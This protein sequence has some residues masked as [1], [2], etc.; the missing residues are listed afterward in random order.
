MS[1]ST[2]THAFYHHEAGVDMVVK[3]SGLANVSAQDRWKSRKRSDMQCASKASDD[4]N[5]RK[6]ET[7]SSLCVAVARR[8]PLTNLAWCGV[9]C[10]W[11]DCCK[12]AQRQ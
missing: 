6:R 12:C 10:A 7:L 8:H 9:V 5:T 11:R 4:A 1:T 2:R 3:E